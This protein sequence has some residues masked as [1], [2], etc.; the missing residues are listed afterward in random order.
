MRPP[1]GRSCRTP[2]AAAGPA[3]WPRH[4]SGTAPASRTA[5]SRAAATCR[6]A[7]G[8]RESPASRHGR[9]GLAASHAGYSLRQSPG[10]R[11]R[12]PHRRAL[13]RPRTPAGRGPAHAASTAR[14]TARD[15]GWRRPSQG[16]R[17]ED[18]EG[19]KPQAMAP[20]VRR[21]DEQCPIRLAFA[22]DADEH[23]HN[24]D[25]ARIDRLHG[26]IRRF[27]SKPALI[28]LPVEA[29]SA[30]PPGRPRGRRP[31]PHRGRWSAGG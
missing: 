11:R 15:R 21:I 10:R 2:R 12:R 9:S 29:A 16:E 27:E 7:C 3:R 5:Y 8:L 13:P 23:A 1:F 17:R 28:L 31:S 24:L 26:R 19:A 22:D 14:G 6:G 4:T 18:E 20:N 25:V 30:S